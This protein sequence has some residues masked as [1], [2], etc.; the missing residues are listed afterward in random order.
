[1]NDGP[2]DVHIYKGKTTTGN[3]IILHPGDTWGVPKKYSIITISN[4]SATE[5]AIVKVTVSAS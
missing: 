3:P 5:T 1:M 4:P 2:T